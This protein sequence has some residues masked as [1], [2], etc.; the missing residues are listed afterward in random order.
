[1]FCAGIPDQDNPL[2]DVVVW[3]KRASI[4]GV[5]VVKALAGRVDLNK[6]VAHDVGDNGWYD[7]ILFFFFCS[8]LGVYVEIVRKQ[9][10]C[11][12]SLQ[13]SEV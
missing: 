9:R 13:A 1:M 3:I 8:F 2:S 12:R 5:L 7:S 6:L 10:V 11:A 4:D